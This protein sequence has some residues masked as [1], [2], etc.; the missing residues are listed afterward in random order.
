MAIIKTCL[1]SFSTDFSFLL[2]FIKFKLNMIRH[3]QAVLYLYKSL[4]QR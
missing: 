3:S 2:Y 1:D 4:I